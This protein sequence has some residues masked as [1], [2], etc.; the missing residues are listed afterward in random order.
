[1]GRPR[2]SATRTASPGA[3]SERSVMS[4]EKTQGW[5]LATRSA[6]LR[7]TVTVTKVYCRGNLKRDEYDEVQRREAICRHKNSKNAPIRRAAARHGRTAIIA[8]LI[9]RE[10]RA[11]PTFCVT[12]VIPPAR[13]KFYESS[14][15]ADSSSGACA[16]AIAD[17]ALQRG[18]EL[19]ILSKRRTISAAHHR[20]NPFVHSSAPDLTPTTQA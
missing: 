6:A 4:L 9:A 13:R 15:V 5:P 14:F 8:A 20:V 11:Q 18:L 17:L 3:A 16:R 12:A 7:L 10:K 19:R 1:M 2:K